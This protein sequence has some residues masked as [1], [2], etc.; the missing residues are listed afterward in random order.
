M[1]NNKN[2]KGF[3]LIELL[4]V[5]AII[6]ILAV[7]V[8]LTLNP[9][10]LL[11]QSRDST[12][13]SDMS[14]LKSAIALYQA[15]VSTSTALGSS[16]SVVFEAYVPGVSSTTVKA[17]STTGWG[18]AS[19]SGI[20]VVN[21]ASRAVDSTGWLPI[22]FSAISSGAP[23]SSL[24]VDP[25]GATATNTS[26]GGTNTASCAYMFE[27]NNGQY[28]IATKM[29]STK[30]NFGGGSSVVDTDGGNSTTT[31]EVGTNVSL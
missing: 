31:Y 7:V 10:Q 28:K 3:T 18:F 14:T 6:A 1:L 23:F 20:S 17:T 19:S 11:A 27:A 5:V 21:A 15:D 25:V 22:A 24:P 29:E 12:R 16:T 9:A 2:S 4:I 30:Y 8:V 26:C 13:V